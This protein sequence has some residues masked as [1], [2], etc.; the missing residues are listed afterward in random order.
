MNKSIYFEIKEAKNG[1]LIPYFQ[2]GKS[3]DSIYNP[4]REATTIVSKISSEYDYFIITGLGSG[5]VVNELLN[6][7]KKC[8]IFERKV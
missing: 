5:K 7:N 3:I 6:A 1:E 8:R 4:D 2:N